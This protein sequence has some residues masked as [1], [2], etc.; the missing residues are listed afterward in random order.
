MRILKRFSVPDILRTVPGATYSNALNFF[1]RLD[2]AGIIGKVGNYIS[3]RAGEFQ[4]YTL[5]KDTGPIMPMLGFGT[6]TNKP[7]ITNNEREIA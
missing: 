7:P 5:L 3:G 1:G 4:T 2:K 6:G